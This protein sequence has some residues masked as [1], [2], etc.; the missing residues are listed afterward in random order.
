MTIAAEQ[1][2][3]P[4]VEIDPIAHAFGKIA[5]GTWALGG[6]QWGRQSVHDSRAAIEV[7]VRRGMNHIDTADLFGDGVSERIVGQ[8]LEQDYHRRE[9]VILA[10]KAHIAE[11]D[12]DAVAER[13]TASLDRLGVEAVDLYYA[14]WPCRGDLRPVFERIQQFRADAKTQAVGVSQFSVEQIEQAL[15]AGPIHACQSTYNLIW[16]RAE[17]EL[18][19]F[20]REKSIA[21]VSC[22]S[23]AGGILTGRFAREPVFAPGDLRP[24]TVLFEPDVWPH[25][26]DA[27][28][29]MKAVAAECRRPLSH[30]ALRWLARQAEVR[31]VVAGARNSVQVNEL[32]GALHGP[33]D[34]TLLDRLTAISDELQSRLPDVANPFRYHP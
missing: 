19:P 18:I 6:R 8:F 33:I 26:F 16:R 31:C 15:D 30:L 28:E 7:A 2:D 32:A 3:M 25:V 29:R 27:V 13:I 17:R 11:P 5:I 14:T 34:D 10:T 9:S 1:T 21:F 23:L 24:R 20:C 12:A 22:G 4:Q